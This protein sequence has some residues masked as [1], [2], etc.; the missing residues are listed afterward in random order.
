[1]DDC[2]DQDGDAKE[3]HQATY[4]QGITE[5][6]FD[7]SIAARLHTAC[8]GILIHL[9]MLTS[10]LNS[11]HQCLNQHRKFLQSVHWPTLFYTTL[12]SMHI[13]ALTATS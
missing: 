6:Y 9:L 4:F 13:G 10:P 7:M 1:M 5:T 12:L 11:Q 8:L 2:L 3:G